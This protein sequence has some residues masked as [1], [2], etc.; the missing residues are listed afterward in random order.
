[1]FYAE[2][3]DVDLAGERCYRLYFFPT[4]F[5]HVAE[6]CPTKQI[7]CPPGRDHCGRTIK[8]M[9]RAQAGCFSENSTIRASISGAVRFARIGFLRLISCNASSP[10]LS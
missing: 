1:M 5:A 6:P 8:S 9:E 7:T 2:R 4:Q 10:P 3:D